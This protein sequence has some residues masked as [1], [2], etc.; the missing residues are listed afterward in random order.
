MHDDIWFNMTPEERAEFIRDEEQSKRPDR[1]APK[2][3]ACALRLQKPG[4]SLWPP[5]DEPDRVEALI[6]EWYRTGPDLFV[7]WTKLF[8]AINK[9]CKFRKDNED[10]WNDQ[11]PGLDFF[12][13]DL[14]LKH[15]ERTADPDKWEAK[16]AR[17]AERAEKFKR[18]KEER[19]LEERKLAEAEKRRKLSA[20]KFAAKRA[21]QK[22]IKK[23]RTANVKR[24]RKALKCG[25][26][27][28]YDICDNG[29]EDPV[30]QHKQR[31]SPTC[32]NV[33]PLPRGPPRGPPA[34][35]DRL[36]RSCYREYGSS[37][38]I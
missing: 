13:W 25:R 27:R 30:Q 10:V 8:D 38:T 29:T 19:D 28:A 9:L 6:V 15:C 31:N 5:F 18:E 34:T 16:I 12:D 7:D 33:P 11:G 3:H 36:R 21:E 32:P 35:P 14:F 37:T 23:S 17:E 20:K 22:R 4:E 26:T 1:L 24:I 2:L